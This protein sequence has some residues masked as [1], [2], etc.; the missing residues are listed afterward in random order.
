MVLPSA[1]YISMALEAA[2]QCIEIDGKAPE[3]ID[4]F[5]FRDVTLQNALLIPE[6][7]AGIEILFTLRPAA[8]NST[9]RYESRYDFRL[10]SVANESGKDVFVEHCKGSVDVSFDMKSMVVL[11]SVR[12]SQ[13]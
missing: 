2:T 6:D 4:S 7:D 11:L 1:A 12:K 8:L 5:E 3:T 13:C 10:T 9:L